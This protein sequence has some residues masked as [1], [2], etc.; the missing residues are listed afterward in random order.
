MVPDPALWITARH[1]AW[2]HDI[3]TKLQ[4]VHRGA[5][6][7][8][9][10]PDVAVAHHTFRQLILQL[11]S[12]FGG[13]SSVRRHHARLLAAARLKTLPSC[14]CHISAQSRMSALLFLAARSTRA[15]RQRW[16]RCTATE[17]AA[18]PAAGVAS[19]SWVHRKHRRCAESL[20]LLAN[21]AHFETPGMEAAAWR[22]RKQQIGFTSFTELAA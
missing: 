21:E 20:A 4:S 1:T 10:A 18:A 6:P 3:P 7:L 5:E 8:T 15:Q 19:A 12:A 9:K 22:S 14:R 2:A 17:I 16:T 13:R 11:R